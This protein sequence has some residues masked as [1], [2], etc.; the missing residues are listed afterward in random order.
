MKKPQHKYVITRRY[1]QRHQ[2]L[3]LGDL[4]EGKVDPSRDREKQTG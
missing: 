3:G 1:K 4:F 2:R